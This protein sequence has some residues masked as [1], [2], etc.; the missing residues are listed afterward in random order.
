MK[1]LIIP[2]AHERIN[3]LTKIRK[4]IDEAERIVSLGDWF[5]TF[6]PHRVEETIDFI[7]EFKND[8][9]WT[10]LIG[11]HDAHYMFNHPY[12]Q[13]S[14]YDPS[15]QVLWNKRLPIEFLRKWKLWTQV[16]DFL[17]SHA[18]F[19]PDTIH[20]CN[21]DTHEKALQIAFDGGF[22]NLYM[23]GEDVGGPD[24]QVGGPNWLRWYRLECLKGKP[25]IVGHT[26]GVAV[27]LKTSDGKEFSYNLDT[28][29]KH[30]A[31]VEGSSVELIRI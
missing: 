27:Q 14:G 31:L 7:L 26:P 23:P 1:T 20:L 25:Q 19:H 13:C 16:D 9:R 21:P 17:V 3:Q 8:P 11:N 4:H 5:D 15:T 12:L 2:D 18:G 10:W 22:H 24:G 30:V 29:L 28:H 6:L